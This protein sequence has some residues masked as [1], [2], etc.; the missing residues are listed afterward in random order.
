MAWYFAFAIYFAA[1]VA[2]LL[3]LAGATRRSEEA[4][5]AGRMMPRRTRIR[6]AESC[7][8]VKSYR[9]VA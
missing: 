8:V 7:R 6:I 1:L 5:A 2:V 9:N 4:E 3:F